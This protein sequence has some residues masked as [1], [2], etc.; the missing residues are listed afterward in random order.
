MT[1]LIHRL[2]SVGSTNTWLREHPDLESLTAVIAD[3]QTAGRGQRGNSWE[4][5]PGQN[6]TLSVLFRPLSIPASRQFAI[7]RAVALAVADTVVS[8]LPDRNDIAV[9]WPND[10]Y[11]G[12]LKIAGILIENALTDT[13][14]TR[15]IIGIGL[16]VN[17]TRFVSDA[18]N[19]VS[20]A[21]LAGQPF[22]LG[23]V[24][25]SL[26]G[27]LEKRLLTEDRHAGEA[28]GG[29]YRARL[30]RAKGFHRYR[31]PDGEQFDAE[32]ADVDP[33]GFLTLRISDTSLRTFAF[34]EVVP[35]LPDI[36]LKC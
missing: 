15:S 14:I 4:A 23:N 9:K 12:N 13:R 7:S 25:G 33:M 6:I 10:I 5:E 2:E 16:N 36:P 32:I 31:T 8:C 27:N 17:Q 3:T 34:K 35:V 20:I 11:A 21:C 22:D 29:E 28:T 19:P 1:M 18:P 30:W 24:T 26:L